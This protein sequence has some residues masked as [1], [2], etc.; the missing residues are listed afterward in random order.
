MVI[1]L[2]KTENERK[3]KNKKTLKKILLHD[4]SL[5]KNF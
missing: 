1:I 4:F 3:S 2:D 5:K